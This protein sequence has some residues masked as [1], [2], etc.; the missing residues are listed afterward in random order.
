MR[1]S[2]LGLQEAGEVEA[3]GCHLSLCDFEARLLQSCLHI[4]L[5]VKIRPG[6]LQHPESAL[7]TW[8]QQQALCGSCARFTHHFAIADLGG[9]R[10]SHRHMQCAATRNTL[11][12]QH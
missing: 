6:C 10:I 9:H 12:L 8:Q 2:S 4:C 11:K 5:S 1:L 3:G 7:S